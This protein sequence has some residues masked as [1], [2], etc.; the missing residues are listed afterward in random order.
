MLNAVENDYEI[1]IHEDQREEIL[2][3]FPE[4]RQYM[5]QRELYFVLQN[6]LRDKLADY[7]QRSA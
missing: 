5:L 3:N 1:H 4:L 6:A 2:N 7:V